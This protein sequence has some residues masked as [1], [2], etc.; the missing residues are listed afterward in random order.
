MRPPVRSSSV[1]RRAPGGPTTKWR[2]RWTVAYAGRAATRSVM[3]TA[4][5]RAPHE[6]DEL[7]AGERCGDAVAVDVATLDGQ[8]VGDRQATALRGQPRLEDRRAGQVPP[9]PAGRSPAASTLNEPPRCG[10]RMRAKSDAASKRGWHHQSMEP[11]RLTSATVR[12]SPM[13]P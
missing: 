7:L 11:S 9:R 13:A 1:R 3:S 10:S 2:G 6:A 5:A 4:A 8:E 12:Q